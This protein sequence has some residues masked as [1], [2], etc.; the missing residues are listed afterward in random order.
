MT[1]IET[2]LAAILTTRFRLV[3]FQSMGLTLGLSPGIPSEDA[4]TV[5]GLPSAAWVDA[6]TLAKDDDLKARVADDAGKCY[7]VLLDRRSGGQ[8]PAG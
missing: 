5:E 2:A 7:R 8:P 6:Q 3:G 4:L 1:S